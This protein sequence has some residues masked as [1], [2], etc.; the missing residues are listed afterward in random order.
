MKCDICGDEMNKMIEVEIN[1]HSKK[2]K[3]KNIGLIKT[4]RQGN[5]KKL[6]RRCHIPEKKKKDT[7]YTKID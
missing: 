2:A 1:P 5:T 4:D 7:S 6:C 3:R